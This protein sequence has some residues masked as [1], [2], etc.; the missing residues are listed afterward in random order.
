MACAG[1]DFG[2]KTSVVAIA[3]RGGIDVVCNEVSNRGTPYVGADYVLIVVLA[4]IASGCVAAWVLAASRC[5]VGCWW[6]QS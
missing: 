5:L 1:I 6:M 2:S 3:R 4:W